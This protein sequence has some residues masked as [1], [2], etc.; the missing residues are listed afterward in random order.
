MEGRNMN[1]YS[2]EEILKPFEVQQV[3]YSSTDTVSKNRILTVR[4]EPA[5]Y[6]LL[7]GITE[8]WNSAGVSDTVRTILSMYFLPVVYELEWKKLKPEEFQELLNEQKEE[9]FSF[10]LARFNRFMKEVSEY[11]AFLK[12]A[13]ERGSQS[14]EYVGSILNKLEEI[15]EDI[16]IKLKTVLLENKKM[17]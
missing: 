13:Q 12:E 7:E 11:L 8:K 1:T 14:L 15:T 16:E 6:S 10:K 9:G 5:L 4:V 17:N 2:I 3:L